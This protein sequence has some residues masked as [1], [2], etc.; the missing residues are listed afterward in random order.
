MDRNSL[1]QIFTAY[2]NKFKFMNEPP[3]SERYKWFAIAKFQEVFDLE[4][5]DFAG[6]LKKAKQA[7]SN[8]IDSYNQ[9]F[10]GLVKLAEI[11]PE[12]VRGLF[13]DLYADDG[14]DLSV[15][16]GKITT[17]LKNCGELV[18]KYYPGSFLYKND[19]RSAMA[20]L[21]FHDPD[22]HYLYK[23]TEATYLA[24]HIGFYD[25]WGP[26][27]AFKLDIYHRFCDELIAE[28]KATPELLETHRSR[29]VDAENV[30]YPDEALHV[31][32]FDI[33][34]C[35][36]TYS[37][38]S[39]LSLDKVTTAE[40]KLYQEN[41][42]KAQQLSEA[43]KKAETDMILLYDAQR[44]FRGLITGNAAVS[45]KS[46][47]AVTVESL[48]GEFLVVRVAESGKIMRFQLLQSI[49]T[50]FIRIEASDFEE[51]VLQYKYVMLKARDIPGRL[52]SAQKDF[53]PYKRYLG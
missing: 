23:A 48:D 13:R 52:A 3:Q 27:S 2:M 34:Y 26:M 14:G 28:I 43:V 50:G 49:A 51:K 20:Y 44:Y 53:A 15:R 45:H 37:L 35:T 4:A 31:L 10:G 24:D 22:H 33:I 38:Y 41:R 29:F 8:I 42:S 17:F 32:L 30:Y 7:T 46:F 39:G 11:E 9:P 16:Q 18:N 6:M 19:Q 1:N 36:H 21:F 5:P 25:D 40:R 47:G 12:T